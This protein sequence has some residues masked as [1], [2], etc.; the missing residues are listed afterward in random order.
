MK[1]EKSRKHHDSAERSVANSSILKYNR[2]DNI[3]RKQLEKSVILN[4]IMAKKRLAYQTLKYY[5]S[6]KEKK[7]YPKKNGQVE[8]ATYPFNKL[9][10]NVILSLFY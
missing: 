4:Q 8:L 1:Y 7:L 3:N 6:K 9:K 10:F 5:Y 2:S